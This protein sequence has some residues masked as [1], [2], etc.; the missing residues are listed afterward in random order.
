MAMEIN[1]SYRS[2]VAAGYTKGMR[3]GS[4]STVNVA[5]DPRFM[6]KMAGDSGLEKEYEGYIEDLQRLDQEFIQMKAAS[7][8]RVVAKGW[9]IDKDGGISG[10]GITTRDPDAKS[11]LQTMSENAEKIR[12]QNEERKQEKAK[13]EEGVRQTGEKG[14]LLRQLQNK[15][16]DFNITAGTFSQKQILSQGR[17]FKG[18]T[19]SPAYLAKAENSEKTAKELDEMLSGVESA[20]KWLESAFQRDGLELVSCGYFINENGEMGSWSVVKK[21]DSMFDGLA[22]Q[23]EKN[24]DRL[25]ERQEKVQEQKKAEKRQ[26]EEQVSGSRLD[27]R[28]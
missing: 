4:N 10:W 23:S 14:S 22:G 27:Y 5:I 21:K 15:Y 20:Q 1:S 25:K 16:S 13:L 9:V 6:A 8:W 3:C 2:F 18:V 7:G 28:I 11:H 12:K 17:G 24:A 19:I 26:A